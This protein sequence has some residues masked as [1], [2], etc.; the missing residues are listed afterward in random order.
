MH[1]FVQKTSMLFLLVLVLVS[2]GC[3]SSTP[4][5]QTTN[6][7]PAD[8]QTTLGQ[9]NDSDTTVDGTAGTSPDTDVVVVEYEFSLSS[10]EPISSLSDSE[11][12]SA[13]E[14]FSRIIPKKVKLVNSFSFSD[15]ETILSN[16]ED[17]QSFGFNTVLIRI[18][19][20]V[21]SEG[22]FELIQ[23]GNLSESDTEKLFET[24]VVLAKQKHWAVWIAPSFS[25][26][27]SL[28]ALPDFQVK[29]KELSFKWA[30]VAQKYFADFFS[31][32]IVIESAFQ[33]LTDSERR[34]LDET[35][36]FY[37]SIAFSLPTYYTGPCIVYLANSSQSGYFNKG[38]CKWVAFDLT[39]TSSQLTASIERFEAIADN[40]QVKFI[41]VQIVD[42]KE[43]YS[44]LFTALQGQEFAGGLGLTN[45][46]WLNDKEFRDSFKEF[47]IEFK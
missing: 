40:W 22:L 3:T 39:K 20:T 33:K 12:S 47:L 30:A 37:E 29:A 44:D 11:L 27:E 17:L 26:S 41:P 46:S 9:S 6:S 7:L 28:I 35:T 36:S 43:L 42:G 19:Y 24:Y 15:I 18:P 14:G 21:T 45:L 25:V 8:T 2:L 38:T 13:A 23:K 4:S 5:D 1:N 34:T 10:S 16:S 32:A 31:P